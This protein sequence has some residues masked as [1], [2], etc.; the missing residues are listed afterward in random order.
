MM[1]RWQVLAVSALVVFFGFFGGYAVRAQEN[2]FE[3]PSDS[4]E[5]NPLQPPG[6]DPST[7][8]QPPPEEKPKAVL[9]RGTKEEIDAIEAK[10]KNKEKG[11]ANKRLKLEAIAEALPIDDVRTVK[12]LVLAA[13]SNKQKDKDILKA[14]QEALAAKITHI[15]GLY[16]NESEEDRIVAVQLASLIDDLKMLKL[17]A[18]ALKDTSAKVK[19]IARKGAVAYLQDLLKSRDYKVRMGALIE[20]TEM[21]DEPGMMKL[22]ESGLRDP[23]P[24][25]RELALRFIARD[26]YTKRPGLLGVILKALDI[27]MKNPK[28]IELQKS[29]IRCIGDYGDPAGVKSLAKII[30]SLEKCDGA[31]P[32]QVQRNIAALD[33]LGRLRTI[34]SCEL[35]MRLWGNLNDACTK[36]DT[37]PRTEEGKQVCQKY[38]GACAGA[39][40]ELCN[41]V[42]GCDSIE[43]ISDVQTLDQLYKNWKKW[44]DKNKKKLEEAWSKKVR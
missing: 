37:T 4:G 10:W 12:L 36:E 38:Y 18:R 43:G 24:R 8:L 30:K 41:N 34:E 2:P 29:Y 44:F 14:G 13:D 31:D 20:V 26:K 21:I 32:L 9:R 16:R 3:P 1:S 35:I 28:D 33:A 7:P 25:V 42:P 27:A 17:F 11:E 6:E 39:M 22:L 19:E 23:H 40:A 15:E 5:G